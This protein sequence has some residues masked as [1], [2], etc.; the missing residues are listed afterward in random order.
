MGHLSEIDFDRWDEREPDDDDLVDP[1]DDGAIPLPPFSFDPLCELI[2][3]YPANET[4]AAARI[5]PELW[6]Y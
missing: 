6:R 2:N 3:P 5:P 4:E 1:M